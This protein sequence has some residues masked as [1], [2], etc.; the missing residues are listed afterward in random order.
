MAKISNQGIKIPDNVTVN[1][2]KEEVSLTGPKGSVSVKLDKDIKIKRENSQVYVTDNADKE[3][4][5]R[6]STKK[7]ILNALTGVVSGWKRQLELL[8]VGFRAEVK[9]DQ[10]ILNVGYSHAVRI[11]KPAG[12]NFSVDKNIITVLGAD[13]QA[14]GNIASIIRRVRPPEPYKGK[15]IRYLGEN[16]RRKL[17]KKAKAV[18]VK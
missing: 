1:I 7:H 11:E 10:L 2:S 5:K 6:Q 8:G 4:A 16:V 12:V 17:G 18:G 15:G 13:K 9:N 14:V 3:R